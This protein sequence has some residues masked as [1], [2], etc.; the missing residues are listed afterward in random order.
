ME[1]FNS[2]V[3][4]EDY[5]MGEYQQQSAE[6]GILKEI[7]FGRNEPL[8]QKMHASFREVLD[9]PPMEKID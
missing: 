3:E 7:V 9:L 1:L 5:Q 2:T 8:L 4:Q 6:S